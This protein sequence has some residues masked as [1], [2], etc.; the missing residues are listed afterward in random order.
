[1]KGTPQRRLR[2]PNSALAEANAEVAPAGQLHPA[3][4]AVAVDGGDRRLARVEV[5]EADGPRPL[6]VGVAEQLVEVLQVGAGAERA[7]TGA[8]DHQHVGR[9]VGGEGVDP[10]GQTHGH[11]GGDA[12]VGLGPVERDQRDGAALVD[13]QLVHT[14]TSLGWGR[15]EATP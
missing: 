6:G 7:V 9:V 14:G 12:V 1:M 13:E 10:L 4:E 2:A 11:G 8:G 15:W 3:G 5:G